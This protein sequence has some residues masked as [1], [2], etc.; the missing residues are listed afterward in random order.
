MPMTLPHHSGYDSS[1]GICW[2]FH[3]PSDERRLWRCRCPAHQAAGRELICFGRCRSGQRWFWNASVCCSEHERS[4]YA[5][6]E[7]TAWEA[8][9]IAVIALA[10]NRPALAHISHGS[11]TDKLKEL[12]AAR[13][14]ARPPPDSTDA[15][16]IEYLYGYDRRFPIVKKTKQR[17][18][19]RPIPLPLRDDDADQ[20][21][22]LEFEYR[23]VR[24]VD[25]QKL[26]RDGEIWVRDKGRGCSAWL[27]LKPPQRKA[28]PTPVDLRALKAE[29]A[30]A[31]PDHGGTSAAFIAAR[32]RYLAAL[33]EHQVEGE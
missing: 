20:G 27:F 17:I 32:Q 29:M 24:F 33:R 21:Y 22:P 19:Y 18:Y 30:A 26:E 1:T 3:K 14:A 12:N 25:R 16:I 6:D 11:A 23:P 15:K 2:H 31:H 9:I 13:R 10:D 4:G 28:E 7:A 5:N 8:V